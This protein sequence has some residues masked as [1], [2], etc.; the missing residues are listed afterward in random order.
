VNRLRP[1][2]GALVLI[3]Q[4]ACGP[5]IRLPEPVPTPL[6]ET[7]WETL[8]ERPAT[9][10]YFERR[11]QIRAMGPEVDGVLLEMVYS[12]GVHPMLRS[13]ALTLLA[14][15]GAPYSRAVLRDVLLGSPE[16]EMR[17][18]A[19]VGLQ[20]ISVRDPEAR[21][22]LRSALSD[23]SR[24]VR[25]NVLQAMDVGDVE[26]IRSLIE[27]ERDRDVLRIARQI[28]QLAEARGARLA[29]DPEGVLRT[30]RA[31][32]EPG[33][34]FHPHR[35]LPGTGAVVGELRV[36]LPG[37][38]RV[39]LGTEVEVVEGVVPAFLAP[40][41]SAV[42]FESGRRIAVWHLR[43]GETRVLGEGVAPRILPFTHGFVYLRERTDW[44]SDRGDSTLL[45]Y[46]VVRAGFDGGNPRIIGELRASA[47]PDRAGHY[48]PVRWMAVSETPEGFVLRGQGMQDFLLPSP[49]GSE[50]LPRQPGS[51]DD[52]TAPPPDP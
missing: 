39:V 50:T 30:T 32:G 3:A 46:D 48:S 52:D 29:V 19:V 25:L 8:L 47:R 31:S 15:R 51:P 7:V 35:T 2:L 43:R 12:A 34:A 1:A 41:R 37:V 45:V 22:V 44:R 28:A 26:A 6:H 23:P 18:A 38:G 14:E 49:F 10:S 20:A 16:S 33:L 24:R 17:L 5:V 27:I 36:E 13:N 40:D 42:V 9:P 11:S 4:S 21:R